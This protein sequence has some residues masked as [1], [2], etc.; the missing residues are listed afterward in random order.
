MRR[1][2]Y[3]PAAS[4]LRAGQ[5]QPYQISFGA[6]QRITVTLQT[7]SGDA[8]LYV[9]SPDA[10]QA[11]YSL[12]D[13]TSLDQVSFDTG[14]QPGTYV[15]EVYGYLDSEYTLILSTG[16]GGTWSRAIRLPARM[17]RLCS[18]RR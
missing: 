9:W 14:Q 2:N 13:G 10:S 4:M 3:M 15:I 12:N 18:P 5:V 7:L 16:D 1:I 8:D 17:G 6:H 11:W